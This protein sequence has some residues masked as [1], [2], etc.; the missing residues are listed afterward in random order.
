MN[1]IVVAVV[2]ACVVAISAGCSSGTSKG[3]DP[4]MAPG[5]KVDP[6]LKPAEAGSGGS[7]KS[8]QQGAV[9]GD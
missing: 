2:L 1:R 8:G 6:R 3:G 7:G 9:K 4:K 5:A